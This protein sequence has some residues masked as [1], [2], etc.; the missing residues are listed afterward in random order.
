MSD[1][2]KESAPQERTKNK[3]ETSRI[4]TAKKKNKHKEQ[5]ARPTTRNTE[6][7]SKQRK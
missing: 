2:M 4:T 1:G 3:S 5:N 6:I 7:T